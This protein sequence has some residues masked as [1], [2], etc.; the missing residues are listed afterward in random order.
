[1]CDLSY[2][3]R[4]FKNKM[5]KTICE[6]SAQPLKDGARKNYRMD[7]GTIGLAYTL[8]RRIAA[9]ATRF[10]AGE[11]LIQAA[12]TWTS[13]VASANVST[14]ATIDTLVV[15]TDIFSGV[16]TRGARPQATGTLV[17]Q[18]TF[19]SCPV[20]HIGRLRGKGEISTSIDTD[21]EILL[22]INDFML[23]DYSATGAPDSGELYTIKVLAAA[24]T[25]GFQLIEG[26]AAKQ[27]LDVVCDPDVY[28]FDRS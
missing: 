19:A 27:T 7:L 6:L 12:P 24:D 9:S 18:T 10:E 4:A 23:I 5:L 25:T 13:G 20:P 15:G 28:R 2:P 1:M 16:A 14:L 26:N 17:A 8:P 22:L 3:F 11:P 21:A